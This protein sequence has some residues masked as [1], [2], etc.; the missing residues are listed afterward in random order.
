MEELAESLYSAHQN[1]I[2]KLNTVG[3]KIYIPKNTE[4]ELTLISSNMETLKTTLDFPRVDRRCKRSLAVWLEDK[5]VAKVIKKHYRNYGYQNM[6]GMYLFPEETLFL[7][8]TNKL[9]LL[10]KNIPVTIEQG[11]NLIIKYEILPLDEYKIYKKIALRGFKMNLKRKKPLQHVDAPEAKKIKLTHEFDSEMTDL[12]GSGSQ[13]ENC[14]YQIFNSKMNEAYN[15]HIIEN[16]ELDPKICLLEN[17]NK[18][19]F[20]ISL[21]DNVTFYKFTKVEVPDISNDNID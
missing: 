13:Q 9:E 2:V 6:S 20:A 14:N 8:E 5:H 19:L 4:E 1:P 16:G 3:N 17:S 7:L 15:L 18:N 10:W 12:V 11:Y 21:P